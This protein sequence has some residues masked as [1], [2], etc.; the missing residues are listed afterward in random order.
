MEIFR[1]VINSQIYLLTSIR[2]ILFKLKSSII[3]IFCSFPNP[4]DNQLVINSEVAG[5]NLQIK[6]INSI[7]V[8]EIEEF[9]ISN[10]NQVEID[11]SKLKSGIYFLQIE[12]ESG[13]NFKQKLVKF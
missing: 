12:G 7:G 1:R 9:R 11:T 13:K 3:E 6:L 4:F 2:K 5:E 10:L 8:V